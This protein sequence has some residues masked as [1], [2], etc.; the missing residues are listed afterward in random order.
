MTSTTAFGSKPSIQQHPL[1][2]GFFLV[3]AAA[4]ITLSELG[5][6][7]PWM[8]GLKIVPII[9]L[10][11]LAMSRLE[12]LSRTLTLVALFFSAMGDVFLDLEFANQFVVG[13]AAFLLAQLTY[14]GNFLRNADF[15]NKRTALRALP[16]LV[17]TFALAAAL[18]P[19]AGELAPAITFY[20]LAILLMALSAAAHRGDSA[21]LFAGAVSFVISDA[22]IGLN[23][24]LAPIPLAGVAIMLTYYGAQLMLVLGLARLRP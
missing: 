18:L 6:S 4:Y 10:A 23:K 14:A 20:L 2:L 12:G 11:V 22:L 24:F 21:L 3:A 1:V 8:A 5:L 19:E 17:G 9:T 13:L 15:R 7:G 16:L